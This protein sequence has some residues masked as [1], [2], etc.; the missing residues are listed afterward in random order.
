MVIYK[1]EVFVWYQ[2]QIWQHLEKYGTAN[3]KVWNGTANFMWCK[4][5]GHY[6]MKDNVFDKSHC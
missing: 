3:Q 1:N 6:K 5:V 2:D 4:S